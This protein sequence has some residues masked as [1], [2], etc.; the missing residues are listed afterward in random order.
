MSRARVV[1]PLLALLA[2]SGDGL[3][4]AAP[5][6][7][8]LS[9]RFDI[10]DS[11]DCSAAGSAVDLGA[12]RDPSPVSVPDGSQGDGGVNRVACRVVDLGGDEFDVEGSFRSASDLVFAIKGRFPKTATTS[13]FKAERVSLSSATASGG[14]AVFTQADGQCNV[15]Y[16]SEKQGALAGRVW[17]EVSCLRATNDPAAGATASGTCVTIAQFRFENCVR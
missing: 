14:R 1:L 12:F 7:G 4:G 9:A 2:C 11:S 15:H 6:Q 8:V 16:T 3:T 5:A 10:T 13:G 17:A